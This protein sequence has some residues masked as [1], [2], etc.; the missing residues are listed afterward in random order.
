VQK[1]AITLINEI[2]SRDELAT[3][4][5]EKINAEHFIN[6]LRNN[7][8][9]ARLYGIPLI[10]TMGR[11][12][13]EIAKKFVE[14]GVLGPLGEC[15]SKVVN[16]LDKKKDNKKEDRRNNLDDNDNQTEDDMKATLACKAIGDLAKHSHEI[17]NTIADHENLPYSLLTLAIT[18]E[19]PDELKRAAQESLLE[20][21]E[22]GDQLRPLNV[23]LNY[24]FNSHDMRLPIEAA[25]YGDILGKLIRKQKDLLNGNVNKSEKKNFLQFGALEKILKLK[26]Q[27]PKLENE[28]P[29]FENIYSPEIVNFYNEEYA[30][31][32]K[33]QF[34]N[35]N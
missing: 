33:E 12:K 24:T 11:Y 26:K 1:S 14:G 13:Q 15:V 20:I 28:I 18:K 25:N 7:R 32:L 2:A 19:L 17:T 27:F 35:K 8:G 31:K 5:N 29:E 21:I 16:R 4:V 23:L 6:F 34:L 30:Q 3:N 22:N 10:S 9:S